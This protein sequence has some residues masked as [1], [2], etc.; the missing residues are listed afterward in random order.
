[1][2]AAGCCGSTIGKREMWAFIS[3]EGIMTKLKKKK[4]K[5]NGER[6]RKAKNSERKKVEMVMTNSR[7]DK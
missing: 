2:Q 6:Q 4:K 5:M 1:M 7:G 3:S